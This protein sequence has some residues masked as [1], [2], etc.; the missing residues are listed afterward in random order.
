[1]T[2]HEAVPDDVPVF[3]LPQVVLFPDARLPLHIFE[4]CYRTM[5]E[6]CLESGG[7]IVIAQM[8]QGGGRLPK[9]A[10]MGVV[11]EHQRLA[12]GRSNIVVAGAERVRLDRLLPADSER[13]PYK[14]AKVTRLAPLDVTVGSA[15]R[16]ALLATAAMFAA[17]VRKR[18]PSFVFSL[19]SGGDAGAI[20]DACAF[21]LVV[22]ATARQALLEELDPRVRVRMVLDHLATQ[23]GS[24]VGDARP[25]VLH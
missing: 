20:A 14:R 8:S 24:M 9:I 21:Q 19:P 5:L 18:D 12:D 10:G 1:M 25:R 2:R 4:P 3:P 22:D 7:T 16:S 11:V 15:D 6:D 13:Y 17:E 23:H